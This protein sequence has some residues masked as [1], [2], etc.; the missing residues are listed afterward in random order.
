MK[1]LKLYVIAVFSV[2]SSIGIF[3][4]NKASVG[5]KQSDSISITNL[6]AVYVG[7]G[8]SLRTSGRY[9]FISIGYLNEVKLSSNKS[10]ILSANILNSIYQNSIYVNNQFI[11]SK[12]AYGIQ[13]S[14]AAEPRLYFD[15]H[16]Q[17][18]RILNS[19]WF[20]GLP[21]ELSSSILNSD[22][23]FQPS[24]LIAPS[25]GYRYALSTTFFLEAAVGAGVMY[26]DFQRLDATP[27]FRIKA[28]Y[29]L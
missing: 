24:I 6:Q 16:K 8:I 12:S 3:A 22:Q 21:V 4:Q 18:S 11:E 13:L 17:H 2:C 9:S 25:V 1:N 14:L 26:K 5:S 10:L 29:T 28:C 23:V 20:I 7:G 19:G 27:Y 15:F